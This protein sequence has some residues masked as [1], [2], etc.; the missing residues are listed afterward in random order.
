MMCTAYKHKKPDWKSIE[1]QLKATIPAL[2][3]SKLIGSKDTTP[4]AIN[5]TYTR[6]ANVGIVD[7]NNTK[8]MAINLLARI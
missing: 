3:M 7:E 5:T 8:S 2:D 1:K 4:T 6:T